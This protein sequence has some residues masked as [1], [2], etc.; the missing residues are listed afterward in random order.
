MRECVLGEDWE[1]KNVKDKKLGGER[2]RDTSR[3]GVG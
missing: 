2:D 1:W 3:R